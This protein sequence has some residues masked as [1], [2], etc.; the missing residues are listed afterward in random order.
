MI[1]PPMVIIGRESIAAQKNECACGNWMHIFVEFWFKSQTSL[2]DCSSIYTEQTS[3]KLA[4]SIKEHRSAIRSCKL[5]SQIKIQR[6][7]C[8]MRTQFCERQ[9]SNGQWW[10]LE[11][12]GEVLFC[13]N[14]AFVLMTNCSSNLNAQHAFNTQIPVFAFPPWVWITVE[15]VFQGGMGLLGPLTLKYH[16]DDRELT[17]TIVY[18]APTLTIVLGCVV[19]GNIMCIAETLLKHLHSN[20]WTQILSLS[21]EVHAK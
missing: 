19:H 9:S 12:K 13:K 10:P 20:I 1:S 21:I 7:N 8:R 2:K 6:I 16:L 17:R 3:R 11:E 18:L 15:N 5:G 14:V 4:T